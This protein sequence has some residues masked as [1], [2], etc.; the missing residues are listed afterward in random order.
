MQ[1]NVCVKAHILFHLGVISR[2]MIVA[3]DNTETGRW[4]RLGY[5]QAV[6]RLSCFIYGFLSRKSVCYSVW[7]VLNMWILSPVGNCSRL[8]AER[9]CGGKEFHILGA[10]TRKLC[11]VL[12]LWMTHQKFV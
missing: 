11:E 8:T 5:Y 3:H 7:F 1:S 4:K 12:F 6:A 9:R 2:V 10:A